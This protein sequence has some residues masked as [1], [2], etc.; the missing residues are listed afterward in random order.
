MH[1]L[2]LAIVTMVT[3]TSCSMGLKYESQGNVE[4]YVK[5]SKINLEQEK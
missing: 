3:V 1:K 4:G 2:I 5:A